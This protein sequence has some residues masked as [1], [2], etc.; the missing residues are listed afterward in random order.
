MNKK[1]NF[2]SKQEYSSPAMSV[3]ELEKIDILTYSPTDNQVKEGSEVNSLGDFMSSIA[4]DL[5]F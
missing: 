2:T 5:G 1:L 3:E 4:N